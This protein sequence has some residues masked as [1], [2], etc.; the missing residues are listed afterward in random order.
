[1]KQLCT[2]IWHVPRNITIACIRVYQYVL[3]PDHSIWAK[4][5]F[6]DGYCKF[7]PSCSSYT[8]DALKRYGFVRGALKGTWRILR[9]NPWSHGGHDPA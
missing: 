1:M 3:S 8:V 6:P 5:F 2:T 9:C 7:D 4:V